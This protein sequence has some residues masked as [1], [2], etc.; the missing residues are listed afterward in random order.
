MIRGQRAERRAQKRVRAWFVIFFCALPSALCALSCTTTTPTPLVAPEWDA[1]PA[2]LL[3]TFC[4]RLRAEGIAVGPIAVVNTTQPFAS[5]RTLGALAG[6]MSHRVDAA[7]AAEAL[8][9]A[10][11]TIPVTLKQGECEWIAVDA[12]NAYRRTDQMVVELSAPMANPF[13]SHQAGIFARVSLAGEHPALYW[14]ALGQTGGGWAIG[15]I[16][17]LSN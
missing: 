4:T 15:F 10:Q 3:E 16:Q 6:P 12:Q 14:I 13:V 5:M 8:R 1:I 11:R 17:P 7:R 2:G 9:G